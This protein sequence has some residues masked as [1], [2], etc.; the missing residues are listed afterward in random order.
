MNID[1]Q[2]GS[3]IIFLSF[4]VAFMLTAM[5]LPE[6]ATFWRPAWV[7]L[8]LIYWVMALP[9][10]IGIGTAWVLGLLIDVLQG[11][12][13][14][15]NAM[16]YALL[17]FLIIKSYQRIRVYSLVQQSA[18]VGFLMSFYLLLSLW[19]QSLTGSPEISWMYWMSAFTNMLLWPW[20]FIVLR[21][22]RRKYDVF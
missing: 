16:S 3:L 5:P 10:R 21:D 2:H 18:I 9:N 22:V 19:V 15:L 11:T 12:I 20:L 14:G 17:A 7:A 13:L 1:K 6:W 8:V 4:L